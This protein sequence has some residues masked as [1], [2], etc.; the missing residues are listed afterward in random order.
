MSKILDSNDIL[1]FSD[2]AFKSRLEEFRKLP[3][4]LKLSL[5]SFFLGR[6]NRGHLQEEFGSLSKPSMTKEERVY[7]MDQPSNKSFPDDPQVIKSIN[8]DYYQL[9]AVT[10]LTDEEI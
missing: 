1:L 4:Q 7:T 2:Y 3:P 6:I 9:Y 8:T 5:P 10:C